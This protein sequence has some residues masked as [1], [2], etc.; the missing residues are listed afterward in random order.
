MTRDDDEVYTLTV[1]DDRKNAE[2][3]CLAH[4]AHHEMLRRIEDERV[5]QTI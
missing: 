4:A 1:P 3:E 2:R 5:A